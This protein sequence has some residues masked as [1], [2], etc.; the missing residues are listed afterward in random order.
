MLIF[1]NQFLLI[2]SNYLAYI[3]F[4]IIIRETNPL[5]IIVDLL[6]ALSS[7]MLGP[8]GFEKK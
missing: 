3:V 2:F 1:N 7:Q 4:I 5:G 8:M 6:F